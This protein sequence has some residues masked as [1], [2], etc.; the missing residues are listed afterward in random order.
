L[1]LR[2]DTHLLT[3]NTRERSA[4][5]CA[6]EAGEPAA[7]VDAASRLGSADDEDAVAGGETQQL[8]LRRPPAAAGAAP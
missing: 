6:L 1:Q 4:R 3:E 2:A 8:A 7:R 5:R